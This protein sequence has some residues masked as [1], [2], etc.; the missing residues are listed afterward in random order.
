MNAP[1]ALFSLTLLAPSVPSPA[2]QND[3]PDEFEVSA[4]RLAWSELSPKVFDRR[5]TLPA[6]RTV[7][8]RDL[9]VEMQNLLSLRFD[10]EGANGT[11]YR[12]FGDLVRA[13]RDLAVDERRSWYAELERAAP[14]LCSDWGAGLTELLFDHRLRSE[15]W[16][17][18]KDYNADGFLI[19]DSWDMRG[20]GAPWS[21]LDVE[22]LTEQCATLMRADLASIKAAENDYRVYLDNIGTNYDE[23]FP[24]DGSY[25]VGD[26]PGG[27]PFSTL[28]IRFRSDLPFPF[29]SYSTRLAILNRFDGAGVLH[30]DIYSTSSDFQWLAG[31]DV[32]L[33]VA[34]SDGEWI[35]FLLVRHFGFDLDGVP[36]GPNN[37]DEA[38]RCSLG[39]LKRNAE[40]LFGEYEGAPRNEPGV[41]RDVRV[42]GSR[43]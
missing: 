4:E 13:S 15:R 18:S 38:I 32:F 17:P 35:A 36:D 2:P 43:D 6:P 5:W 33:P 12:C 8:G 26:D 31:R 40:R 22:P 23:I 41:L 7:P 16:R 20:E 24:V 9:L 25:F 1:L 30:T 42:F 11:R 39:N 34:T 3:D 21:D 27:R 37:R 10:A 19:A 14:E 28:T 29:S